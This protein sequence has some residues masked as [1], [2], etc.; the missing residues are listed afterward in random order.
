MPMQSHTKHFSYADTDNILC[1][2]STNQPDFNTGKVN[3][4]EHGS[5]HVKNI[6]S[7]YVP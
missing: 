7:N 3:Y 2:E 5:N 6:R 1:A 4:S